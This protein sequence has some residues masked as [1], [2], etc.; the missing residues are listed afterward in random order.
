M[1]SEGLDLPRTIRRM[2]TLMIVIAAAGVLIGF[3]WRGLPVAAGYALGSLGSLISFRIFH[4]IAE[5]VGATGANEAPRKRLAVAIG[6]R[7][8]IFGVAAYVIVK[9]FEVSLIAVFVGLLVS[10]AAVILEILYELISYGTAS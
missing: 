7:Y 9:Y 2:Y 5:R 1:A 8:L 6:L 3:A 4:R 10:A